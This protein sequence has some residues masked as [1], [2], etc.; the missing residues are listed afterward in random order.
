VDTTCIHPTC[1]SR[2]DKE[3]K[4]LEEQ[5]ETPPLTA[6][7]KPA[8]RTGQAV[9]DQT[10]HKIAYYQPLVTVAGGQV[11]SGHRLE[12]PEFLA[13]VVSTHGELGKQTQTLIERLTH[14]YSLKLEREGDRRDGADPA[15]LRARFRNRLRATLRVGAAKGLGR[16]LLASG[17]PFRKKK[18]P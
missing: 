7:G 11:N 16:M 15:V 2:L 6:K 18:L 10:A 8:P 12:V 14:S 9:L 13:A 17:L 4:R 3:V 1:T 5:L